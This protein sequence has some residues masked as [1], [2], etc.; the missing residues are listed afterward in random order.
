MHV[1]AP[2]GYYTG[3]SYLFQ[4]I[5]IQA[6]AVEHEEIIKEVLGCLP[7]DDQSSEDQDQLLSD[8]KEALGEE[9]YYY[10]M[11]GWERGMLEA[12]ASWLA[13]LREDNTSSR[14]Y[15]KDRMDELAK[16]WVAP[17]ADDAEK[18]QLEE[19]WERWE[20][21]YD[22]CENSEDEGVEHNAAESQ[23]QA[24]KLSVQQWLA[25][26]FPDRKRQWYGSSGDVGIQPQKN[27]VQAIKTGRVEKVFIQTNW[28]GHCGTAL[29]ARVCRQHKVSFDYLTPGLKARLKGLSKDAA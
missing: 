13:R 1:A 4:E 3:V 15:V 9:G 6:G 24:F 11:E 28:N 19:H 2:L 12:D 14:N 22:D 17:S 7:S 29:V 16:P 8:V 25:S 10:H 23:P 5:L 27:L 26:E 20:P 21:S 18:D